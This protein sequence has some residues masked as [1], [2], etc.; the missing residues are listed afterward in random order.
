MMKNIAKISKTSGGS[1]SLKRK[2]WNPYFVGAALG[3]AAMV[4]VGWIEGYQVKPANLLG[5]ALGSGIFGVGM[6]LWGYSDDHLV[7]HH[8]RW[9][10]SILHFYRTLRPEVERACQ[11]PDRCPRQ[12]M[13]SLL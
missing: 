12:A 7:D 5:V 1:F 4:G 13:I 2:A 3:V 9:H 8:R 10:V 11:Q 6:A